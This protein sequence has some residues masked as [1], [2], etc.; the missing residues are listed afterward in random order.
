MKV[1]TASSPLSQVRLR[2]IVQGLAATEHEWLS[3]VRFEGNQRWYQR[4]A[5]DDDHEVWLLSWLPGQQTGFHDHGESS[6]AFTV[7]R[8]TLRERTAPGRRPGPSVPVHRGETR[9]FGAW[10]VHDVINASVQPAVSVHAYS[11]PLTSMRRFEFGP[12]GLER[13]TTETAAR[14]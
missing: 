10:Y 9:S 3:Q 4:L 11:P 13:V 12:G 5:W 6:G 14:W 8:G 2:Q 1:R 7:A